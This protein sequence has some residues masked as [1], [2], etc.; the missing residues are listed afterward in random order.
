MFQS[1]VL[2]QRSFSCKHEI[3]F[4]L[5]SVLPPT[6]ASI[7][8]LPANEFSSLLFKQ[9]QSFLIA[10]E[11]AR[12]GNPK[13][14]F[15]K[16]SEGETYVSTTAFAGIGVDSD[17]LK[18]YFDDAEMLQKESRIGFGKRKTDNKERGMLVT[19]EMFLDVFS[20]IPENKNSLS[21]L[22]KDKETAHE[23]ERLVSVKIEQAA[24]MNV[25]GVN[26]NSYILIDSDEDEEED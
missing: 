6:K 18:T 13:N 15:N 3:A 9:S 23:V 24:S 14:L 16:N 4:R 8:V 12:L 26:N 22:N 2:H 17:S 19:A 25:N 10:D 20:D 11:L 1:D 21:L 7:H 5:L